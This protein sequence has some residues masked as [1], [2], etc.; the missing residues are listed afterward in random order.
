MSDAFL[1]I[2]GLTDLKKLLYNADRYAKTGC[3]KA[4]R[5]AGDYLKDE[6]EQIALKKTGNLRK[7]MKREKAVGLGNEF[8]STVVSNAWSN[9]KGINDFNYAYYLHEVQKNVKNPTT[10]NTVARHL[11]TTLDTKRG[12]LLDIM[13]H[14]IMEQFIK[15]GF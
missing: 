11:A 4:V 14:N 1:K 9:W 6:A 8:S 13:E 2:E 10:P 12:E 3:L 7:N 15:R 5:E